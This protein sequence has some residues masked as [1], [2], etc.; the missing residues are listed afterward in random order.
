VYVYIDIVKFTVQ[1]NLANE[2]LMIDHNLVLEL[3]EDDLKDM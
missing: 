2:P 1:L 3:D